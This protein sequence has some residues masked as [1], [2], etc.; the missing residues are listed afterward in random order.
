M[1]NGQHLTMSPQ[2]VMSDVAL[3]SPLCGMRA[4]HA[5]SGS[6][7]RKRRPRAHNAAKRY[8]MAITT[9]T[10]HAARGVK[11]V[12]PIRRSASSPE[13]IGHTRSG[14]LT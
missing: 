14:H 11:S 5:G 6:G 4:P 7:E 2:H 1:W 10:I 8:A 12:T 3:T 9:N 13:D